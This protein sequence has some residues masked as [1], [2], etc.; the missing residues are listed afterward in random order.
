MFTGDAGLDGCL[1]EL[2]E[3]LKLRARQSLE[4]S[5]LKLIDQTWTVGQPIA[6]LPLLRGL[7]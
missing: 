7:M 1:L 2:E 3:I 5:L 4:A 6:L